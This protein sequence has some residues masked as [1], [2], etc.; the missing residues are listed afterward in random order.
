MEEA[1]QPA[2]E[3]F[4]RRSVATSGIYGGLLVFLLWSR[5]LRLKMECRSGELL[6]SRGQGVF[7]PRERRE[8]DASVDPVRNFGHQP[9]EDIQVA[10]SYMESGVGRVDPVPRQGAAELLGYVPGAGC[11]DDR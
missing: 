3:C 10:L 1:R 8:L 11:L 9:A 5:P 4:D 2:T 6:A 7:T